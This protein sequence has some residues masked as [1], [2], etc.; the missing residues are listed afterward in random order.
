MAAQR[1]YYEVLGISKNASDAEIKKAYRRAALKYHPDRNPGDTTAAERFRESAAAY[2]VL[3]DP[4]KRKL[5]DIYG[6][7]FE[8]KQQAPGYEQAT[9][10]PPHQPPGDIMEE[11]YID[12]GWRLVNEH[13]R[14]IPSDIFEITFL[15]ELHSGIK[16]P[17]VYERTKHPATGAPV[18]WMKKIKKSQYSQKRRVTKEDHNI[19]YLKDALEEVGLSLDDLSLSDLIKFTKDIGVSIGVKVLKTLMGRK[20]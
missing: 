16:L 20:Y 14:Y 4:E 2:E 3:S 19:S 12:L 6:F 11:V 13:G 5:Y 17:F 1:D 7:D 18:I 9:T 15:E 8:R 10:P